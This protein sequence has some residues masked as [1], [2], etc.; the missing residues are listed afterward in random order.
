MPE[1]LVG[2]P[3][4]VEAALLPALIGSGRARRLLLTG[5]TID[6]A[7]ALDWGLVDAVAKFAIIL[8][9]GNAD[10]FAQAAGVLLRVADQFVVLPAFG[11]E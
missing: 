9:H 3:S 1:I 2:I 7:Q 8:A 4:V 10:A 6:A 5:E 11:F